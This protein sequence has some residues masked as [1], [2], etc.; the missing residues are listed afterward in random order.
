[1]KSQKN[2]YIKYALIGTIIA[3]FILV[4]VYIYRFHNGLS[5]DH[6][7]F[8]DFGSYLGSITGLLAF[9]GVLYTIRDSQVNR[10]IDSERSTFYKLLELYQRQVETIQYTNDQPKK[11][12]IEAFET[13]ANEAQLLFC[14]YVIYNFIKDGEKLPSELMCGEQSPFNDICMQFSVH[15]IKDLREKILNE[16]KNSAFYYNMIDA[17]NLSLRESLFYEHYRFVITSICERKIKEEKYNQL[18][19]FIRDTGDYLYGQH[20][21]YLGQYYRNIYY[22]LNSLIDSKYINDYSKIF[23]AQ[24]SSDELT[25]LLFNSISSQSTKHTIHLLKTF[26]IFNNIIAYRLPIFGYATEEKKV[27]QIMNS[28]FQEFMVDPKNK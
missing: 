20:G 17:I 24:L 23:R 6:H 7:D 21:Q 16:E 26:D 4:V 18:Y 11:K 14:A 5:H 22:L 2:D 13:Y 3:T 8:A 15:S 28:L 10:Q 19:N 1:M 27:K 12:G 25:I 9:I